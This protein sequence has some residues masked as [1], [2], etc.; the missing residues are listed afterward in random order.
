MALEF[1]VTTRD[2]AV[3][4]PIKFENIYSIRKDITS[5]S[6]LWDLNCYHV[7]VPRRYFIINGGRRVR[8]QQFAKCPDAELLYCKR[9]TKELEFGTSDGNG[10]GKEKKHEI[11]YI[12]GFHGTVEGKDQEIMIH[13]SPNGA[14]WY[15]KDKR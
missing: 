11:S 6:L 15:W 4:T 12:L 14:E 7:N 2:R 9:H 10:Q 13:V 3:P 1:I 5:M 8:I